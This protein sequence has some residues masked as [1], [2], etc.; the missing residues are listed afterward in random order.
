MDIW[1]NSS[2][3]LGFFYITFP[4]NFLAYGWNDMVDQK[5]DALNPRK[6]NFGLVQEGVKNN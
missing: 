4:L 5:T 2:F 3:W 1:Q 6:D